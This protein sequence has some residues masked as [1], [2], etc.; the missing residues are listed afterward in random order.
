M[1][2][3]EQAIGVVFKEMNVGSRRLVSRVAAA[4]MC[5][6]S[7]SWLMV[8]VVPETDHDD[9]KESL[10]GLGFGGCGLDPDPLSPSVIEPSSHRRGWFWGTGGN[11]TAFRPTPG[12]V[13]EALC[14]GPGLDGPTRSHLLPAIVRAARHG[15]HPPERGCGRL[16]EIHC[17]TTSVRGRC[18]AGGKSGEM[19]ETAFLDV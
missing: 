5:D 8:T 19:H 4:R 10:T 16:R 17:R 11:K 18:S 1:F 3:D 6:K 12:R 2:T 13:Q 7:L 15:L 9:R 14:V